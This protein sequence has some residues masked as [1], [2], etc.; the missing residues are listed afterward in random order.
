MRT[1]RDRVIAYKV[2]VAD[3][4]WDL[5]TTYK[6]D[7]ED[8]MAVRDHIIHLEKVLEAAKNGIQDA[9]EQEK[10]GSTISDQGVGLEIALNILTN[11]EDTVINLQ[12]DKVWTDK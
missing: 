1:I 10:I 8:A 9:I 3:Y 2:N 5:Y 11:L 4:P 7:K 12:E 6:Q